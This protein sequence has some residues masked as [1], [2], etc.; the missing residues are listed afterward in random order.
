M[1]GRAKEAVGSLE[2]L[3]EIWNRLKNNFD[4]TELMMKYFNAIGKLGV[5][6]PRKSYRYKKLFVQQVINTMQDLFDFAVQYNLTGELHYS[7]QLTKV[8]SVL[9]NH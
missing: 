5:M 3:N 6:S 2:C 1:E 9:E 7:P 4:N 8:V